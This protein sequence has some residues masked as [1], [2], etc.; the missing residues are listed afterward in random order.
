M[1]L[2][3]LFLL[4]AFLMVGLTG[5]SNNLLSLVPA[6]AYLLVNFDLNSIL[7]Q[8]ELKALVD[9]HFKT[10]QKDYTDFYERSGINPAKDI[11]NVTVFMTSNNEVGVLVSGNFDSNEISRLIQT[12]SEIAGK[13][14][15]SKIAGL[16][17]V[18]NNKNPDAN[19]MFLNKHAVAFAKETVLK[20]IAN[21][22]RDKSIIG[23]R[24]FAHMIRRVDTDANIWGTVLAGTG[25]EKNIKVPVTGLNNLS[26][27]FFAL[28]YDKKFNFHFTGL[29]NKKNE[30]PE[31]VA[32]LQNFLDAFKGWTASVPEFASMLEKAKIQD[33]REHL[34]RIVLD[35]PAQ[36]FKTAMDSLAKVADKKQ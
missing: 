18:K 3:T 21:L 6:D 8:P 19:M 29:V 24:A 36:E 11:R 16:Q 31:F 2:R 1:K 9:E 23:N 35:V 26:T 13:F 7:A 30:L 10:G 12:D 20:K 28:S 17:A 33:N 22:R 15:I 5:F 14:T 27:G 34:A 4:M 25:W 32:G